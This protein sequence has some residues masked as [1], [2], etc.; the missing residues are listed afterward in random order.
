[1]KSH[2]SKQLAPTNTS[3]SIKDVGQRANVSISTVS[4]V[5]NDSG[6]VSEETR[7]RVLQAV[8]ELDY[9]QNRVAR[10]LRT[11]RSNLIGLV[12]PDISNEFYSLLAKAIDQ[13]LSPEGY[14]LLLCNT[15]E[16]EALEREVIE[17]LVVNHV[18]GMVIV[19]AGEEVND[20]LVAS[21]LPTVMFD[22]NTRGTRASNVVFVDCDSYEGGRAAARELIS[23]GAKRLA[24]LRT[25]R[26]VIPMNARERGFRDEAQNLGFE[27]DKILNYSVN[28]S[29]S[30]AL[31]LITEVYPRDQFDGLFCAAD[32]IAVGAVTAL[33][34]MEIDIPGT[35]QI[36]GFDG[37]SL[38]EYMTPRLSTILQNIPDTANVIAEELLR[39]QAGSSAPRHVIIPIEFEPRDTTRSIEE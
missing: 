26:P 31:D 37:I 21:G 33:R 25:H 1:M 35:V 13:E 23:R 38:G 29:T 22:G 16:D 15:R 17:S 34:N 3:A 19:S 2:S 20:Q 39:L 9:T 36:I 4:R 24:L 7:K 12:V 28:I 5:L 27:A 18:S 30:E 14:Q 6:Y 8:Q 32:I 10:S 11:K